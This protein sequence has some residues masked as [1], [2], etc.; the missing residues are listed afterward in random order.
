[1]MWHMIL[2]AMKRRNAS[3]I[4][5]LL[6][7]VPAL[8]LS[9]CAAAG[10]PISID[11]G[12][13]EAVSVSAV[14]QEDFVEAL[15]AG[16]V[17][18][19]QDAA[20]YYLIDPP[21]PSSTENAA[22]LISTSVLPADS[23]LQL[24]NR[25]GT[26]V[27]SLRLPAVPAALE[28]GRREHVLHPG[29]EAGIRG[30]TII[31]PP[32]WEPPETSERDEPVAS[33]SV[34]PRFF[35]AALTA[36]SVRLGAGS[37]FSVTR[38]ASLEW[39][40]ELPAGRMGSGATGDAV[41]AE[42]RLE[43]DYVTD[44]DA[45]APSAGAGTAALERW[46]TLDLAGP[47]AADA[48]TG[49]SG[50]T[51][52]GRAAVS[53][54]ARLTAGSG[55]IAIPGPSLGFVPAVVRVSS[56]DS[57]VALRRV[58]WHET[59]ARSLSSRPGAADRGGEADRAGPG[60]ADIKAPIP[61]DLATI[62]SSYPRSA[63]RRDAFEVF[64][65][66]AYPDILVFDT[67]DYATQARLFRRLAFFVEKRGF[68]G[69][70]LSDEELSGRHGWNAH[71]YRPQGLAEFFTQAESEAVALNAEEEL[72]RELLLA[73]GVI[74]RAADGYAP[75]TGGI[76][77]ISQSSYP[78]LRELLITHEA[79]HGV[80][81]EEEAFRDG[82]T[83]IWTGLSEAERSYWRGLLS[84]M[85]Y[86]PADEYL[87][88]NEFQAYLMQQPLD[89]VRGYLRGVLAPRFANARPARRQEIERFLAEHPDSFVRA[90]RA[91]EE[92]LS[93]FSPLAPGD[94]LLL[95]PADGEA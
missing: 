64:S 17:N 92:L 19:Q 36:D 83:E 53:Y 40:V 3:R 31:P 63:W 58:Q 59:T 65:W 29:D 54:R 18:A 61:A 33:L 35:G 32:G 39:T 5:I 48:A 94:V 72:L 76:L 30:V 26:E 52:G 66:S 81:Y 16:D 10:P 57:G 13:G 22:V 6:I 79:Y 20:Y 9:G 89:R 67:A 69:R 1:M 51:T 25:E 75:G 80:F 47:A 91:V 12:G 55:T 84:Y 93:V 28:T 14:D 34:S 41:A 74:R 37:A 85:T 77:S 8:A 71:N 90:A 50:D 45:G 27:D 11:R 87:M 60:R 38:G 43:I 95:R 44:G 7:S 2:T 78:L 49:G 46:V 73:N 42:G 62:L 88:I 86:D 15:G 70:L 4:T 24:L 68:R 23:R 82:V 21:L 56:V